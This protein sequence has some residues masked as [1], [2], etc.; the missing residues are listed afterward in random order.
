MNHEIII[1]MHIPKTGGITLKNILTDV[2]GDSF[3]WVT[4]TNS[5]E[6]AYEK[7]KHLD[8]YNIKAIHG[9]ISYGLHEYLPRNIGY[10]YIVFLRHPYERMLSYHNYILT[11][12]VNEQY[13]WD[14]N[15]GWTRGMSIVEWLSDTK[16]ATQDNGMTRF[17]S[18]NL[19]L[20]TNEVTNKIELEDFYLALRNV[21]KLYFIGIT[22]TFDKSIKLLA[23]K[24]NWKCIPKYGVDNSFQ[25][26]RHIEDLSIEEQD[27]I[28]ISQLYDL[29]L[30]LEVIN[31]ISH[32]K[33]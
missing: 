32:R 9:H 17:I 19:N 2:Y 6:E 27:F 16:L 26:R 30:Y 3:V 23:E 29:W 24:L 18:G 20:N 22:E 10:K 1:S 12:P 33:A 25:D 7:I 15:Y 8:L 28:C 31:W 13:K 5:P 14:S 4:Q 11:E 21:E